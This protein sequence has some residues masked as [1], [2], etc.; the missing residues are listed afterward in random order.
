LSETTDGACKTT[1]DWVT[2]TVK[3]MIRRKALER[4]ETKIGN[5]EVPPQA[6]C[7]TER[8]WTNGTKCYSWYFG[9]Y[10]HLLEKANV[11]ADCL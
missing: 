7:P 1:L 9:A 11:I 5:F 2:K 4:W 6:T 10:H 8:G 3:T